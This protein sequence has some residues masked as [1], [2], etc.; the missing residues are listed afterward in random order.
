MHAKFVVKVSNCDKPE[1]TPNK[2][3]ATFVW[4]ISVSTTI[5]RLSI[6]KQTNPLEKCYEKQGEGQKC[7][8]W[9]ALGLWAKCL[10]PPLPKR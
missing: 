7:S 8:T 10:D 9:K 6:A 4:S 3:H 5:Y 1:D 2:A